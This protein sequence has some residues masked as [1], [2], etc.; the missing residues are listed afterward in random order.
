MS[1]EEARAPAEARHHWSRRVDVLVGF[2]GGLAVW[3]VALAIYVISSGSDGIDST[4]GDDAA[5][6]AAFQTAA[7]DPATVSDRRRFHTGTAFDP[8]SIG[9]RAHRTI[10]GSP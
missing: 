8:A 5:A 1:G 6:I 3:L 2:T 7:G 4:P 10:R 9:P